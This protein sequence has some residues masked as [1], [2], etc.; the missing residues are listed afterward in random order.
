MP[1]KN[2]KYLFIVVIILMSVFILYFLLSLMWKYHKTQQKWKNKKPNC[3][4][5]LTFHDRHVTHVSNF[6]CI[7]FLHKTFSVTV[8]LLCKTIDSKILFRWL[9][10][11]PLSIAIV[12]H[13][14]PSGNI[15]RKNNASIMKWKLLFLILFIVNVW[16]WWWQFMILEPLLRK[17]SISATFMAFSIF[18]MPSCDVPH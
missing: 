5:I 17:H 11:S 13:K 3:V 12:S 7:I 16:Q 4:L 10:I 18:L 6:L 8:K 1:H 2:V 15:K 9:N 14:L